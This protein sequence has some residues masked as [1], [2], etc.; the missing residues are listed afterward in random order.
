M[1]EDNFKVSGDKEMAEKMR[2][3]AEKFKDKT[4]IS[5]RIEA[6]LIMTKAKDITPHDSGTLENSGTV[7]K[8]KRHYG[9]EVTVLMWFGNSAIDYAV[10]QHENLQF[11][12]D[13]GR[14]AKYLEQ[15]VREAQPGFAERVARRLDLRKL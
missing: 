8:P 13:P 11:H 15:P 2:K 10:E 14:Q 6:E 3:L 12:H 1:P 5:V 7:D 4:L 9:G